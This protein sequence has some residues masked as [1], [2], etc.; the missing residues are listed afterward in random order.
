MIRFAIP[1]AAATAMAAAPAALSAAEIQ[2]QATGPVIELSVTES[3]ASDPDIANISAGVTTRAATAVQAMQQNAQQMTRVI[4][5]IEALGVDE[6]DI[7]TSGINLNAQYDYDQQTREQVFRG[8]QV[9]NT[10][11]V[12]LRDI[13]TTGQVL[14]ALVAAGATDL[15]GISWS[16]DDP[17]SARQQAR[18]S[19][20]Q[21]ALE[22]ARAYASMSGYSDVR[23]LEINESIAPSPPMPV[24]RKY[25]AEQVSA[26]ST[27]VRP[28]QVESSVSVTVKYEMTR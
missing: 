27:P 9:S 12:K 2:V 8:Y 21:S 14:D 7:Q 26:D 22:Q 4:S 24:G 6:D 5:Q 20:V 3:V 23:L 10:V 1:L 19:A 16:V 15:G 11:S 28:G 25:A 13:G 18:T 17:T